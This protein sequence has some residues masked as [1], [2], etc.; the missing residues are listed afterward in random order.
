MWLHGQHKAALRSN[1]TVTQERPLQIPNLVYEKRNKL[2]IPGIRSIVLVYK[3]KKIEAPF[4]DVKVLCS[5]V[6]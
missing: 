4:W 2:T 3:R 6:T 1:H 5:E